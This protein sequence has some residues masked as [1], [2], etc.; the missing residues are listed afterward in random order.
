LVL[1][2]IVGITSLIVYP[3]WFLD[4]LNNIRNNYP[5]DYASVSLWRW[6]GAFA[7]VLWIPPLF[8]RLPRERR[9]IAIGAAAALALPYY[10][11]ADLP[12]LYVLPIGWLPLLGNF[13]YLYPIV[14]WISLQLLWFVP[15]FAYA[16]A[17]WFP[18]LQ[19]TPKKPVVLEPSEA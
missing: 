12:A 13:G 1:P 15:L 14:G 10:Q 6:I 8:M 5:I 11:Q 4:V 18:W 3:L 16:R 2:V 9:I 7:L 19:V 17:I